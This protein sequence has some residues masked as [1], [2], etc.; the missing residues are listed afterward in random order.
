MLRVRPLSI[1]LV[2]SFTISQLFMHH[3]HYILI[4]NFQKRESNK[5]KNGKLG[6]R[7]K[8][9]KFYFTINLYFRLALI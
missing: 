2:I 4:G 5:L 1:L 9:G 3:Y 6:K 7:K 8:E